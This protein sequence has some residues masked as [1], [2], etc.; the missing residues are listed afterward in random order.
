[1]VRVGTLEPGPRGRRSGD[2]IWEDRFKLC[3]F[4]QPARRKYGYLSS[5]SEHSR[6]N[7]TR[8]VLASLPAMA[9]QQARLA[10]RPQSTSAGS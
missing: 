1:M 2:G 10:I 3:G 6:K 9:S 7:A 4:D 8:A 5:A